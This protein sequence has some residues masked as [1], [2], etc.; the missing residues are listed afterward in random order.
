MGTQAYQNT[1][2]FQHNTSPTYTASQFKAMSASGVEQ[3]TFADG[4]QAF[5]DQAMSR[6]SVQIMGTENTNYAS[7]ESLNKA[8]SLSHSKSVAATE[9]TESAFQKSTSLFNRVGH[10]I[11]SGTDFTH[12]TNSS[13]A[14]T[15]QDFKNHV[16]DIRKSTGLTEAQ[17]VE[18]ALGANIGTGNALGKLFGIN[19]TGSFSSSAAR[20]QAI[21]SAH[22]IAE[23]TGYSTSLDKVISATKALSEGQH[24]TKGVELATTALASFN[25]AKRHQEESSVAQHQVDTLSKDISSTQNKGFTVSK[26]LTVEV[27][28][29]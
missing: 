29:L 27:Y 19:G 8:M 5:A 25:Q 3:S 4:T 1:S 24:D 12:T 11:F 6:L 28:Y 14:K 10:D 9:A 17:S 21:E 22:H 23:Q 16:Q 18:A 26:D 13:D 7:Q 2:A 15:L 20:Q